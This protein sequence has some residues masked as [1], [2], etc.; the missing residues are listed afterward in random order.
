VNNV[1]RRL[2]AKG[3]PWADIQSHARGLSRPRRKLDSLR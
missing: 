3:D 1:L 2:A